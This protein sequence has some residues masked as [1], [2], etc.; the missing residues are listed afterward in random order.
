MTY[1]ELV[2]H[3]HILKIYIKW[4]QPNITDNIMQGDIN[5]ITLRYCILS[6][7]HKSTICHT[8][9]ESTVGRGIP[10]EVVEVLEIVIFP[11]DGIGYIVLFFEGGIYF[12]LLRYLNRVELINSL[13]VYYFIYTFV[14]SVALFL[15]KCQRSKSCCYGSERVSYK[16]W[17]VGTMEKTLLA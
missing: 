11:S 10:Y 7:V 9:W 14:S 5:N 1:G 13:V 12:I 6:Q 3:K 17:R 16:N 2:N 4:E 15:Q 8:E